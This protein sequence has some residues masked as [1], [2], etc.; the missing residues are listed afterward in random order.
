MFR[1]LATLCLLPALGVAS[2]IQFVSLPS[3]TEHGTYNGFLSA[4][5]DGQQWN[6]VCDDY[7]HTTNVPSGSLTY[8]ES[9][10]LA[11]SPLQYARFVTPGGPTLYDIS[12]YRQ[13]ALLV[14]GML[15]TGP[16]HSPD[17]TADYQYALWH[18]FDPSVPLW[19]TVQQDLLTHTA[20]EVQ[21]NSAAHANLYAALRIYTPSGQYVGNQEFLGLQSV[22]EPG[23][24][25]LAGLA[26]GLLFLGSRRRGA[27]E[28]RPS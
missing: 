2:I 12:L 22:P 5:I 16:S 8:H 24:L 19:R 23:S 13:A 6:L 11:F 18:L 3:N 20:S 1:L 4:V 17:L 7:G 25:L 21:N 27:V 26:I 10:L 28:N 15:D 14:E 9:D